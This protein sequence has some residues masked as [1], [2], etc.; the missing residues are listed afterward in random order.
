[1]FLVNCVD[2]CV[3][4]S[5]GNGVCA[6]AFGWL[7]W[8]W[9]NE[10]ARQVGMVVRE[11]AFD[12]GEDGD[13]CEGDGPLFFRPFGVREFVLF[14]VSAGEDAE[15]DEGEVELVPVGP[16]VDV[17]DYA[18]VPRS[19]LEGETCTIC[20]EGL[21]EG[22][23]SAGAVELEV[24]EHVFHGGCLGVWMNASHGTLGVVCPNCRTKICEARPRAVVLRD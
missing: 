16:A 14:R 13:G 11:G 22:E 24:C 17:M 18:V 1:M 12:D 21:G 20:L 7:V 3:I 5:A 6:G 8:V 9:I 2:P 15:G 23:V 19:L 4:A 10:T